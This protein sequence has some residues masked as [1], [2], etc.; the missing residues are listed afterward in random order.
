[1]CLSPEILE[2]RRL[3]SSVYTYGP[4]QYSIADA[5][6]PVGKT[7]QIPLVTD[8][9]GPVTYAIRTGGR[10]VQAY[11]HPSTNTFVQMNV[12]GYDEPM[13]FELFNDVAPETTRRFIGLVNSGFY[14]GLSFHRVIN[15]FVIQGGSPDGTG[16]GRPQSTG[17]DE[18]D[19][20][21]I[22]SGTGQLAMANGAKDDNGSQFFITDGPQRGLDFNNTIFGQ[23]VR[24][25]AT[26]QAISSVYVDSDKRPIEPVTISSA[27]VISDT[28]DAVLQ[29][30]ALSATGTTVRVTAVTAD[31]N[32]SET[33]S[34]NP[35][36]DTTN[37][38][39]ILDPLPKVYYVAQNQPLVTDLSATDLEGDPVVWNGLRITSDGVAGASIAADGHLVITPQTGFTGVIKLLV[40]VGVPNATTRG[41]TPSDPTQPVMNGIYDTQVVTVAVGDTPI[42]ATAYN[43]DVISGSTAPALQVASFRDAD[44]SKSAASFTAKID[45]GDGTV[46]DGAIAESSR[47]GTY[48]V[49]GNKG[50]R[51]DATG[52]VP[53]TVTISDAGGATSVVEAT[54][55]VRDYATLTDGL[56]SVYGT[57]GLDRIGISRKGQYYAVSVDGS[58]QAIAIGD[59][60]SL[61]VY[62]LAARDRI[63]ITDDVTL[64]AYI[65]AGDGNDLIYGG[66]GNEVI[67]AGGGND[68]VLCGD[69][70]T[71]VAGGAGDDTIYGGG[72]RDK[73][74]GGDGDDFISGGPGKDLL[75]G[76]D[77]DDTLV[78]G[79]GPDTIYG[80]AGNDILNGLGGADLIF[81]GYGIDTAKRYDDDAYSRDVENLIS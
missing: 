25:Q 1:M 9:D 73:L 30:K 16:T 41:S 21:T 70:N 24:G 15:N 48:M 8:Y 34:I 69:G 12:A 4:Q 11:L 61:C 57:S 27:R 37:A 20:S 81:G 23:L 66:G 71:R 2:S 74:F 22:F 26:Q 6:V 63:Q 38:P 42:A 75:S 68:Y 76:D 58:T 10:T 54:A 29:L 13:V 7:I 45:W 55:A 19:P 72:G 43:L 59:V 52:A 56:L 32:S 47:P 67:N 3:L 53:L 44:F 50:Y 40:G 46:T 65:E 36:A 62:G 35:F 80:G 5:N 14:N 39:P 17:D 60:T 51:S 31:G 18:F 79:T 28:T 49:F 33:F 64:D 78:G 77:G